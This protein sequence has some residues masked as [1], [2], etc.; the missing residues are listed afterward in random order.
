MAWTALGYDENTGMVRWFDGSQEQFLPAGQ[1]PNPA[2]NLYGWD[3]NM[4]TPEG[5][6]TVGQALAPNYL[7]QGYQ[8]TGDEDLR[9][10][11][12]D[13]AP[14][15]QI[16]QNIDMNAQIPLSQMRAPAKDNGFESLLG[17]GAMAGL[18]YLSGGFGLGDLFGSFG[19]SFG[20]FG[21]SSPVDGWA[22]TWGDIGGLPGGSTGPLMPPATPETAAQ[23]SEWGLKE[24]APGRWEAPGIPGSSMS[25]MDWIKYGSNLLGGNSL[26]GV[27]SGA[28]G[29]L[30][31]QSSGLF[32]SLFGSGIGGVLDKAAASAPVLAAIQYARN[33]DPFDTSRLTS[34]YDSYNPSAM[35]FEYDQNTARGRDSLTS[36]LTNRGV[37]GSSFGNADITNFNTTRDLGRQSL[38]NQGLGQRAGIAGQILDADVKARQMKNQLYGSSLLALGNVFGGRSSPTINFGGI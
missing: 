17:M 19:D 10:A 1:D 38:I 11:I 24:V 36:S 14:G 4:A 25:A 26:G 3:P 32:G 2:P 37:M 8:F 12:A 13:V 5:G 16:P 15:Y 28:A 35:A 21:S 22:D 23:L 20:S 31:S 27:L 18:G 34:L 9:R 30:G 29:A 6:F 33:Q 7:S